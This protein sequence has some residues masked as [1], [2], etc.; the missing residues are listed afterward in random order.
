MKADTDVFLKHIRDSISDIED[1]TKDLNSNS[2][3][4]HTNKVRQDAVIRNIE[5]IGEAVRNIPDEFRQKH[6]E[7]EWQ[8]IA[9]MRS[10]LIHDYFG[11]DLELV[12]VVVSKNLKE[13]KVQV[14][15]LLNQNA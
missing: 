12:W 14:D 3:L 8:K 10:K 15:T 1:Y 9:G 6:P 13:L 5:I 2:F 7:I 11:V 4:L